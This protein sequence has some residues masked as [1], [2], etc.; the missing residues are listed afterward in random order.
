M[1]QIENKPYILRM[2]LNGIKRNDT[3]L[4]QKGGCF[5]LGQFSCIIIFL[6]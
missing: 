5:F 6:Q 4:G 3:N 2:L 1:Q